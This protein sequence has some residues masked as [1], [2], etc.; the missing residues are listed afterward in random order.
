MKEPLFDMN[1]FQ[2][3]LC[4]KQQKGVSLGTFI[5]TFREPFLNA[6]KLF[7]DTFHISFNDYLDIYLSIAFMK[8]VIDIN[9]FDDWL[10]SIHGQ[11]EDQNLSMYTV[12][13][14]NYGEDI[15]KK[16]RELLG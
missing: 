3:K 5:E 15:A 13:V 7:H 14:K 4:S 16:I 2:E 12:L 10:H 1:D 8:P 6:C 11:Y 9:E